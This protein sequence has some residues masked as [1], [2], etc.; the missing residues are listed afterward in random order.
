MDSRQQPGR[1]NKD[2]ARRLKIAR[3][4]LG[5]TERGD[6]GGFARNCSMLA[7][8]YGNYE[9][10]ISVPDYEQAAKLFDAYGITLD[11]LFY[12][13]PEGLPEHLRKGVKR[14]EKLDVDNL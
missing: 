11:W 8:T 6:Q 2:V 10:G 1:S 3:L 7:S 12:G 5:Y 13:K 4:A 9:Q 14:L